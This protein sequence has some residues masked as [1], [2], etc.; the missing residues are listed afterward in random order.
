MVKRS[1]DTGTSLLE[2]LVGLVAASF[3]AIALSSTLRTSVH[4]SMRGEKRAEEMT[5]ALTR[6]RLQE[7]VAFV[8]AGSQTIVAAYPLV[9]SKDRLAFSSLVDDGSFWVGELVHVEV[10]VTRDDEGATLRIVERGVDREDMTTEVV[11]TSHLYDSLDQIQISFLEGR[12]EGQPIDWV[13]TWQDGV[14]YPAAVK[15][16][17]ET[18]GQPAYPP[19]IIRVGKRFSQRETSASSL[20]PPGRPSRP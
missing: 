14:S 8:P 3:V 11:T 13:D 18:S 16:T 5:H 12:E 6:A 1:P 17:F 20:S 7:R 10:S 9:G 4:L 2:L 19:L 15:F